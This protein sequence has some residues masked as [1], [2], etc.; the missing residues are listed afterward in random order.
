[1]AAPETTP[2]TAAVG[3]GFDTPADPVVLA[4]VGTAA[5]L[6]LLGVL[7]LVCN[8]RRSSSTADSAGRDDDSADRGGAKTSEN[9][10]SP[11]PVVKHRYNTRGHRVPARDDGNGASPTGQAATAE[12]V[13]LCEMLYD[14]Y[15]GV[16]PA[17]GIQRKTVRECALS[18]R[19]CAMFVQWA[20]VGVMMCLCNSCTHG[21]LTNTT[22]ATSVIYF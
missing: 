17:G 6:C 10:G 21:K 22:T 1:M 7:F 15:D 11:S 13:A 2:Y 12:Q 5:V 9:L 4:A 18:V 16:V 14:A 19:V 3:L 8:G 20:P